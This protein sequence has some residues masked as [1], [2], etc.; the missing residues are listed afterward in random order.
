MSQIR[1]VPSIDHGNRAL[2]LS[3]SGK[4]NLHGYLAREHIHYGSE[5]G[6]DFTNI[7]FLTIA[8]YAL[9]AS[10]QLA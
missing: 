4:M 9:K 5:E 1:S 2:M 7:Y 6:I 3:G 8:H 10:N